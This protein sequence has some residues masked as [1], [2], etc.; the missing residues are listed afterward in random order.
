MQINPHYSLPTSFSNGTEEFYITG[1]DNLVSLLVKPLNGRIR[2]YYSDYKSYDYLPERTWQSLN[3]LA[4][5]WKKDSKNLL[6]RETCY[7]WFPCTEEFLENEEK[8]KQYLIHTLEYLFWKL[9]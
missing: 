9:K 7:T 6:A 3:L 8:Q 2:Q 1:Q 4:N 5:L